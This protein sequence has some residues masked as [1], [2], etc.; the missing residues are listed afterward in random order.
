MEQ[1]GSKTDAAAA[2]IVCVMIGIAVYFAPPTQAN[3]DAKNRT[4]RIE[5]RREKFIPYRPLLT[6]T[7]HAGRENSNQ[8]LSQV[9]LKRHGATGTE[10]Q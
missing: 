5:C 3:W 8:K 10:K 2:V 7:V 9:R 6:N 4:M 1:N